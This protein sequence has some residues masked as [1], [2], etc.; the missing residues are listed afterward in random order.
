MCVS[1]S[2]NRFVRVFFHLF[3]G[4]ATYVPCHVYKFVAF[5]SHF[6]LSM[7][8]VLFLFFVR[9]L[10]SGNHLIN[11]LSVRECNFRQ[12][13]LLIIKTEIYHTH[14]IK[15]MIICDQ[16]THSFAQTHTQREGAKERSSLINKL[17]GFEHMNLFPLFSETTTRRKR[18]HY[19]SSFVKSTSYTD[20]EKRR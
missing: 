19:I 3:S 6:L 5:F 13:T 16:H 11:L 14:Q 9:R 1:A 17:F 20:T 8:S 7:V 10:C 4:L 15:M 2:K 18:S 12:T